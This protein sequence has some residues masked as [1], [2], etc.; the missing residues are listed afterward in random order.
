MAQMDLR[1]DLSE[2][3]DNLQKQQAE[4]ILI[5]MVLPAGTEQEIASYLNKKEMTKEFI[6]PD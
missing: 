2:V 4:T 1:V 5:K 6:F 3:W